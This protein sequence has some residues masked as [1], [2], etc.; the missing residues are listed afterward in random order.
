M[1][2]EAFADTHGEVRD[3]QFNQV[4]GLI[5]QETSG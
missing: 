5:P 1:L 2:L 3:I 4:I